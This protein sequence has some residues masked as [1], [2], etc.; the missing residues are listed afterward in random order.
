MPCNPGVWAFRPARAF[1]YLP[2]IFSMTAPLE[3]RSPTTSLKAEFVDVSSEEQL[4]EEIHESSRSGLNL[5][6]HMK[7]SAHFCFVKKTT[8][9]LLTGS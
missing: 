2:Y 5:E 8:L 6:P 3:I 7:V 1:C 9:L 4:D